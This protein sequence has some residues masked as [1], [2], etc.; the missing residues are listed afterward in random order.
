RKALREAFG[1]LSLPKGIDE[2]VKRHAGACHPIAPFTVLHICFRSHGILCPPCLP[3]LTGNVLDIALACQVWP[4]VR[5]PLGC[6]HSTARC[7]AVDIARD[8]PVS[9]GGWPQ[10]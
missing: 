2:G 6:H 9:D 8:H 3:L 4:S 5:Q 7:T 10:A 1:R